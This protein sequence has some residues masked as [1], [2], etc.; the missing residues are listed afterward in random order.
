MFGCLVPVSVQKEKTKNW[1]CA[2]TMKANPP[3]SATRIGGCKKRKQKKLARTLVRQKKV[4]SSDCKHAFLK[5]D[6]FCAP[7]A[8]C[9]EIKTRLLWNISHNCRFWSSKKRNEK[10]EEGI[11]YNLNAFLFFRLFPTA[12]RFPSSLGTSETYVGTHAQTAI[13]KKKKLEKEKKRGREKK[14]DN[15]PSQN[16]ERWNCWPGGQ[17]RENHF[18]K[19]LSPRF[20]LVFFPNSSD[21]KLNGDFLLGWRENYFPLPGVKLGK[22]NRVTLGF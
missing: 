14:I 10:K 5:E 6:F 13:S 1:Q 22:M 2:D 9:C 16:W 12:D 8:I 18:F 4:L 20:L 3:P 17:R 21:K 15:E 11:D 19:S 7:P